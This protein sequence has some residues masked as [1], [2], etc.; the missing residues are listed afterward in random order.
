VRGGPK[1]TEKLTHYL[2]AP[3]KPALNYTFRHFEGTRMLAS[4]KNPITE[5][6]S[7]ISTLFQTKNPIAT[8]QKSFL[9]ISIQ[10]SKCI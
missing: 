4:N 5:A 9:Y 10:I 7:R 3:L 2:L 8:H 6:N 1:C